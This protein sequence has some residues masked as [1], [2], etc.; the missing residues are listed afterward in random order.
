V[1][2]TFVRIKRCKGFLGALAILLFC[3]TLSTSQGQPAGTSVKKAGGLILRLDG[4]VPFY[5]TWLQQDA[6][7]IITDEERAAF[8]LLKNDEERD[9]F[10]DAFWARRNPTP[11]SFDNPNKDEH[12]RR[13]VY[14]NDHFGTRIPGWKSDRGRMY[15]MF[16]PPDEIESYLTRAQ[17][18]TPSEDPSSYPLEVWHYRYLEGIG[19]DVVLE[20]VDVCKCGEYNMAMTPARDKDVRTSSAKGLGDRSWGRLEGGDLQIFVGLVN[21]PKVRFKELEEKAI[22]DLKWKGLPFE[23][24]TDTVK[25]T[26]VTSVVPITIGFKKRDVNFVEKDGLR[27]ATVNILGR[28]TTLTGRVAEMFETTLTVDPPSGEESDLSTA[29]DTLVKTLA[30]RNGRYRIEIAA[31]E[32]GSDRWGRWVGSVKVG[33]Q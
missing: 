27:R 8:K 6:V 14:A 21:P 19:E 9:R 23:V 7:W 28:V 12:Y 16:G 20:F 32:A 15:V 24:R 17:D 22:G 30:L 10:V 18:K 3:S 11:D 26:D 13:I 33:D 5:K 4:G 31:E 1:R 25:A 29:S 2:R